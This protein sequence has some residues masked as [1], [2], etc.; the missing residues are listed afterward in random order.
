MGA[1]AVI[2]PAGRRI[3]VYGLAVRDGRLLLTRVAV[4]ELAAGQWTLPGGGMEWGEDPVESLAREFFEETGMA[5]VG[6]H[7]LGVHSETVE[8]GHGVPLHSLQL[9]Y[10]VDTEGRPRPETSSSTDAVD[11][12]PLGRLPDCVPLVARSLQFASVQSRR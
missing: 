8:S 2:D 3:G 12:F 1:A 9:V 10:R 7:P 5:V 6:F 4:S 11:W